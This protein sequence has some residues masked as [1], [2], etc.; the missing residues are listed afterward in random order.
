MRSCLQVLAILVIL[1]IC[2]CTA[3]GDFSHF[4]KTAFSPDGMVVSS[5]PE[6]THAGGRILEGG[7]NAVDAAI[8]VQLALAVVYPRAGNIGGG[9]FMVY[10]SADGNASTL[11]FREKAPKLADRDMYLDE[12]GQA[13][14]HLSK[15]GHLAA[16]VPGSIAGMHAA[17]MRY[18]ILPWEVLF[19]DAIRLAYEGHRITRFEAERLNKFRADFEKYNPSQIPFLAH[20]PWK[21][22]ALLIQPELGRTLELISVHGPEVFYSGEIADLIISEMQDGNGIM[23]YEDLTDYK[24]VWREP[25]VTTYRGY[26][27]LTMPP[28]SSGGVALAQ[29]LGMIDDYSFDQWGRDD[30]RT[31]HLITEVSRRAFADRAEY[32]G[33]TD[34]YPVPVDS[35]T[36]QTYLSAQM[37]NFTAGV[38]TASD[39]LYSEDA[40]IPIESCETTHL[41]VVDRHGNAVALTTTLN[42]N[43][44]CKVYIEGAGFFLNNEMDDFSVKPGVPNYF[45]LIGAEAN[46][47]AAEKRMLSSMTPTIVEKD[48]TFLMTIGT[49]GGSSIITSVFQIIVNV[50]DFEMTASEAVAT[51]RFH[52][53]WLPDEITYEPG[54][55]TAQMQDSLKGMGHTLREVR[56]IGTVEVIMRLPNGLYE[57]AADPRESDHAAGPD[58]EG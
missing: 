24:P 53:Q 48:E 58:G 26:K 52:H 6:A 2:T 4:H 21:E 38:A 40:V 35:I 1:S 27:I 23:S 5:H 3:D 29:M 13:I 17:H 49:P 39:H 30:S 25:L 47:I 36:D 19:Q 45:G 11:D 7:G 10:R 15:E 43:F 42:T 9:G 18:G 32:L 46:A 37:L 20:S 56:S 12:N 33:D 41:S 16:G 44:G 51:G 14:Q 50:V 54:R 57:G 34:F 8:A 55:F 28:P 31:I 22:G